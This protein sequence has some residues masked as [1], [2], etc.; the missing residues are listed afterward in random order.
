MTNANGLGPEQRRLALEGLALLARIF[1]GPGPELCAELA[2]P[3]LGLLAG[4][5]R[6]LGQPGGDEALRLAAWLEGQGPAEALC[7]ATAPAFVRLFVN[8]RGGVAAPLY[9]SCYRG[10][11]LLMGE[12]AREMARRLATAGLDLGEKAGEPPDH[13]SVELE[14]LGLMLDEAWRCGDAELLAE[15]RDLAG[16]FMLP[17]VGR[18]ADR[19]ADEAACPLYPLAAGLAAALLARLAA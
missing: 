8:Q 6:A 10:E 4:L 19:L 2:G 1:W 12:P 11:G 14:L 15:A 16:G 7:E 9:H 18:L 17:W 3:A 13:L 5:A